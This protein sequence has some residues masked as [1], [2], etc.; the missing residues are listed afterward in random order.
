MQANVSGEV[1]IRICIDTEL[2]VRAG[3]SLGIRLWVLS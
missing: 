1:W 2:W 3:M